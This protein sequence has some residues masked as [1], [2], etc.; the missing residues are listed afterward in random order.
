M[1]RPNVAYHTP[2]RLRGVAGE[3]GPAHCP[4][5]GKRFSIVLYYSVQSEVFVVRKLESALVGSFFVQ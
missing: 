2:S 5:F 1:P 3:A 4:L